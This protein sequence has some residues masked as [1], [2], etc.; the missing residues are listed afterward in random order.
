MQKKAVVFDV[1][2]TLYSRS[3]PFI[4]ACRDVLQPRFELDWLRLY[5][6]RCFY[7]DEIFEASQRGTVTMEEMYIYRLGKAL[8]DFGQAVPDQEI[9]DFE[10]RYAYHQSRITLDAGMEDILD[11]LHRRGFVLGVVTNGPSDRQRVKIHAL[12]LEKWIPRSHWCISGDVGVMKPYPRIF[13]IEAQ[14]LSLPA[15]ACWYIGDNY[16]GDVLAP[17]QAGW[18]SIWYNP[19]RLPAPEPAAVPR[20]GHSVPDFE[21]HSAHA[22]FIYL[23]RLSNPLCP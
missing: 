15:E 1:D 17:A 23:S 7:G 12:G 3:Q 6:R 18:H 8:A 11:D 20:N 10:K 21:A 4:K 14:K 5:E 22:L 2:D 16:E 13:D 19:G 9:L